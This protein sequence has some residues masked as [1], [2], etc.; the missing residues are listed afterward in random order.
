MWC[1]SPGMAPRAV[2]W[3]AV[4]AVLLLGGAVLQRRHREDTRALVDV[5]TRG[6]THRDAMHDEHCKFLLLCITT[7]H[8]KGSIL[9]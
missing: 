5:V 6:M 1:R 2:V 9:R 8:C 7:P 3:V 4:T